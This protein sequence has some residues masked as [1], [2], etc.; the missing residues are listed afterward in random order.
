M[1]KSEL[2]FSVVVLAL[3]A[4]LIG[5]GIWKYRAV[6]RNPVYVLAK[7]HKIYD[8]ENGLLYDF[9]YNYGSKEYKGTIKGFIQPRDSII[10]LKISKTN[11]RLWKH[12]EDQIPQCLAKDSLLYKSWTEYPLCK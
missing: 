7:I 3:I 6:N 2:I 4:I 11:P 12:I 9:K 10:L 8:T 5:G 1:K